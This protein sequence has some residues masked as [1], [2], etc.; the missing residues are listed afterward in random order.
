MQ[1]IGRIDAT[2]SSNTLEFV[3]IPDTYTDLCIKYLLRSTRS[4]F[5][6]DGNLVRVNGSTANY[7]WRRLFNV[8]SSSGSGSQLSFGLINGNSTTANSFAIGEMYIPNYTASA[9]KSFSYDSLTETNTTTD[10]YYIMMYAGLWNDTAAIS[11]ITFTLGTG[12]P[13]A[14]GSFI[15][16]YGITAGSDGIVAVS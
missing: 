16:V 12:D 11:S 7:S 8:A 10:G 15:E 4:V 5:Y 14:T 6:V 3:S 1:R 2:G 13:F 9:A